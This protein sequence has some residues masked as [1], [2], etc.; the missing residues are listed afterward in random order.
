MKADPNDYGEG[1]PPAHFK[2]VSEPEIH[3][4]LELA[5]CL[6]LENAA[7]GLCNELSE[8]EVDTGHLVSTS[9]HEAGHAVAA[10]AGFCD[11][12]PWAVFAAGKPICDGNPDDGIDYED[13]M[14]TEAYRLVLGKV[15]VKGGRPFSLM[16]QW[17]REQIAIQAATGPI[18]EAYLCNSSLAWA[19]VLTEWPAIERVAVA[20]VRR[21]AAMQRRGGPLVGRLLWRKVERLCADE[22]RSRR[23]RRG[24]RRRK[25]KRT[26]ASA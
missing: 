8:L 13:L 23:T 1:R 12:I 25:R 3:Q 11:T 16:E 21:A 10:A 20:L 17:Q 14:A 6:A 4:N 5:A 26:S 19:L 22:P 15:A 7:P 18:V 24:R 2:E 9:Y